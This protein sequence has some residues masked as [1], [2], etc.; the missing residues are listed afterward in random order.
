[1]T[2]SVALNAAIRGFAEAG[3]DGIVELTT[4]GGLA[5]ASRDAAR[6]AR[7]LAAFAPEVALAFR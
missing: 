2:S 7:A 5:G 1:V 6:G 4:G 3:S